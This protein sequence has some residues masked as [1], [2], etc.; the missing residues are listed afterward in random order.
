M[1]LQENINYCLGCK[2][3]PC[4]NACPLNNDITLAIS[5]LKNGEEEKAYDVFAQTSVLMGMCGRICP[6]EFQC[7]GS[8]VRGIKGEPVAIGE[9]ETYLADKF[10]NKPFEKEEELNKYK[11]AVIGAGP[12]G[13]T[14]AAFLAKRGVRVTLFEK[15]D[16]LGGIMYHGIPDFRLPKDLLKKHID[17]ILD[18]GI[19]VKMNMELSKD[20]SLD[21]LKDYDAIYLAFGANK[22]SKM[23]IKGE[24]LPS[25]LYGNELL[26]NDTWPDVKGKKV[27]V[28]GGGNTAMDVCRSAKL[29][30]GDV[31]VVYRRSEKEMPATKHEIADAK[32]EGV[33]FMFLTNILEVEEKKLHCIK[34]TLVQKEGEKR[35]S[36]VNIEGSDFDLEYDYVIMAVGSKPDEKLTQS[37]DLELTKWNS[38]VKDENSMTSKEGIFVG[39]DLADNKATV[40]FASRSG[41]DSAEKIIEYLKN[42]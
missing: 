13:L 32:K 15:H 31:T 37:L 36:P 38:I 40:A 21:D 19:E 42:K 23:R 30:G 9:I 25:V 10:I 18:L 20:F 41:R 12:S 27:I 16:H 33:N 4:K 39:G 24:D 6:H 35:L 3:K 2:H 14:C 17:K 22:S 8:C 26:E 29:K 1:N 5:Y 28:S 11:V 7:Q 34:T